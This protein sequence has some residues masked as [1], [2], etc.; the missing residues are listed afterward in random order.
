MRRE[1]IKGFF[2]YVSGFK[3]DKITNDKLCQTRNIINAEV[4]FIDQQYLQ[5]GKGRSF[6]IEIYNL[7]TSLL[8]TLILP[9]LFWHLENISVVSEKYD[10][11][12][13]SFTYEYYLATA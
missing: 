9:G 7:H 8:Q 5:S 11:W 4:G 2:E 6:Q 12:A 3:D 1:R 10:P 13:F